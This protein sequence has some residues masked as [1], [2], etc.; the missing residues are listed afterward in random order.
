MI[1]NGFTV[2]GDIKSG[3]KFFDADGN[4]LELALIS[5]GKVVESGYD[6]MKEAHNCSL[7]TLDKML[8]ATG[9]LEVTRVASAGLSI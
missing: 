9:Y 4:E 7:Q 3:L 6:V 2:I 8:E 5:K 1:S